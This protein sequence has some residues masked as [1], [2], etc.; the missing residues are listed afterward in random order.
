LIGS[1]LI[2]GHT[3]RKIRK[4]CVIGTLGKN[5]ISISLSQVGKEEEG[6]EKNGE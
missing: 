5:L 1:D 4:S 6:E 2:A 3:S